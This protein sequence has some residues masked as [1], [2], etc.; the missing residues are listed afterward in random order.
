[1]KEKV[2]YNEISSVYNARYN[3]SPLEGVLTFLKQIVEI[4][5]PKNIL[6][7]GCGTAHWLKV[8]ANYKLQLYGCD[9]SIG[10]LKQADCST[11]NNIHLINADAKLLPFKSNTLEMIICVNAIHH[12]IDKK[13]FIIDSSKLL[14]KNGILS[15][16]GLD[17]RDREINW[18]LYKFF[19][20][21][22]QIDLIRFPSFNDVEEWMKLNGFYKVEKKLVHRVDKVLSGKNILEDHFIDKRGASQLALLSEKEYQNGLSKIKSEIEKAE[23]ENKIFEFI[24]KLNFYSV[25]GFKN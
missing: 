13:K 21:T 11:I 16:I 18:S 4:N 24:V 3:V 12:F 25:T 14:K 17:P 9:Y 5:S 19:E 2:N 15:I 7:V 6:E 10:M 23:K 8:L 1:M 20:R 22:Y